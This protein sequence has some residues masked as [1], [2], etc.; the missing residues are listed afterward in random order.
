MKKENVP[1]LYGSTEQCCGCGA[2]KNACPVGAISMQPDDCGYLYPVIDETKCIRCGKCKT[3]CRFQKG[4]ANNTPIKTFAAQRKDLRALQQSAS[5]GMFAALA[6]QVLG[7]G[8]VVFGAAMDEKWTL[9]HVQVTTQEA[10]LPLLGSKYTQSD[11]GSTYSQVKQL[12]GTGK[13]VLY[14]GTPCQI[15]GLY[16]YLGGD[17][18]GLLTA[19]L[20]CH[21]V[22][23]NQMLK[24]YLTELETAF[25]GKLTRFSFRDKTVGWGINGSAEITKNGK[26]HVKKV[27]QSASSYLYYFTQ[28]WLYRSSCYHCP[29]ACANRPADLTLGDY[30]GIEKMHPEYLGKQGFCEKNGI[31][32][33][34]ANTT[35]GVTALETLEGVRLCDSTFEKASACNHQLA[36][37]SAPGKRD[38]ILS[39]YRQS[40]WEGLEKRFNRAIGIRKYSGPIKS[41]LPAGLKRRLKQ[42]LK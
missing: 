18:E 16:G 11:T 24:D 10:L 15:A 21:G 19:D 5:G 32:L 9:T 7:Q 35:K 14:C 3:V 2:C 4:K 34:V 23:S 28:G 33:V 25:G 8:G 41:L 30:W 37:P 29:Y 27:W 36:K 13:P 17:Q 6:Q 38:E 20:V 42:L 40:G 22:P 39:V 1:V 12:L 31:S 26:K